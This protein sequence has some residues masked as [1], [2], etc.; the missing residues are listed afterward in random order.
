MRRL[1]MIARR[2]DVRF[3]VAYRTGQALAQVC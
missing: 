3:W 2:P 1:A